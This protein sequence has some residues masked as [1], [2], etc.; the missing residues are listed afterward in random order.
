MTKSFFLT[1]GTMGIGLE[2]AKVYQND[3]ARLCIVSNDE[4]SIE[5]ASP[6]LSLFGETLFI[7]SG[8]ADMNA[9]RSYSQ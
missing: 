7:H 6:L 2:C 9:V 4:Q 1:G 3:G 5:Q 8:V